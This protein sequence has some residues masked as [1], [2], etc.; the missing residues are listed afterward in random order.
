M[1]LPEAIRRANEKAD[2]ALAAL[3]SQPPAPIVRDTSQVQVNIPAPVA[4]APAPVEPPPAAPPAPSEDFEAKYKTLQGKYNSEVPRL[5]QQLSTLSAQLQELRNAPKA[6]E[7]PPA[8]PPKQAANPK[9]VDAF[10]VDMIEMVERRVSDVFGHLAHP[11]QLALQALEQRVSRLE[12]QMA[13]MAQETTKTKEQLFVEALAKRVPDY[14][15]VNKLDAWLA[16][17]GEVDPV[18]GATRQA[19]LDAA[20]ERLNAERA[21][22]VFNAFKATHSKSPTPAAP[23]APS[24]ESQV[25]PTTAAT[26]APAPAQKPVYTQGFITQFY[27]D[28]QRGAYRGREQDAAAIEADI[29]LAAAEGRIMN[30]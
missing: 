14:E 9:D 23:A 27:R 16:W 25:A 21:A 2:Q 1:Q 30:R 10:G 5:Q 17:L 8:P 18:Y 12:P 4:A 7:P 22:A 28:V 29:N 11:L 6:P 3:Q 13:S 24:L 26:S 20:V 15:E 19:A